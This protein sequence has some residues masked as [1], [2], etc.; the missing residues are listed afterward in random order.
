MIFSSDVNLVP[1]DVFAMSL[2]A[3]PKVNSWIQILN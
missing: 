2:K 1:R 3:K